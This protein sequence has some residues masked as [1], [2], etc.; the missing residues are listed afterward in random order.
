MEIYNIDFKLILMESTKTDK[1]KGLSYISLRCQNEN[2]V[3]FG[4]MYNQWRERSSSVDDWNLLHF[5]FESSF[6]ADSAL[7]WRR[8]LK[9]NSYNRFTLGIVNS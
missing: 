5:S 6:Q 8:L 2:A 7:N 9:L 3:L 1:Y 4:S